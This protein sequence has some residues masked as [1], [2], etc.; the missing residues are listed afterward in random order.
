MVLLVCGCQGEGPAQDAVTSRSS[1]TGGFTTMAGWLTHPPR[2]AGR[3]K[4]RHPFLEDK[5]ELYHVEEDYS[6]A[7][8]Q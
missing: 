6:S 1:G 7:T 4:P 8:D 3:V 5:W 2:N